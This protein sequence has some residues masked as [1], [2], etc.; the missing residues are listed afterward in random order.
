MSEFSLPRR[1]V[2]KLLGIALGAP[3]FGP[4]LLKAVASEAIS[5]SDLSRFV[6][7]SSFLLGIPTSEVDSDV[8]R[9]YL[10]KLS[11]LSKSKNHL[12][13]LY[14]IAGQN[15]ELNIESQLT[16]E[17]SRTFAKKV[18]LLWYTG[19]FEDN[20]GN[21][22]RL[23]YGDSLMFK[24]FAKERPAPGLC[25]GTPDSWMKPPTS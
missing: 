4:F 14:Q 17:E 3:I 22:K 10:A 18:I 8:A 24:F 11:T 6:K 23:F 20:S 25:S 12:A 9:V 19:V 13:S 7:I 21:R 2:L 1:N 5:K 16:N 15:S